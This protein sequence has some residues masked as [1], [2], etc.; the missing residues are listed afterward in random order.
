MKY[1]Y[2]IKLKYFVIFVRGKG[3]HN[4]KAPRLLNLQYFTNKE[5]IRGAG[6]GFGSK[7]RR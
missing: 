5:M 3:T 6:P 7:C 4:N 1:V 2:I